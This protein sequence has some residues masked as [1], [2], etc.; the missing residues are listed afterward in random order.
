MRADRLIALLLLLQSRGR[1]T[2]A[3][4]AT[5][6][7]VSVATARRDLEALSAAG[8]PVY[9]QPGRG[10]GWQLIGGARTNLTGLSSHESQALFWL[11]GT[12][13]L[14]S[15]ETQVATMKLIRALPEPMKDEAERL[16]TSIH[17]DHAAWG[18]PARHS[19]AGLGVL[20]DA[21]VRREAIRATYAPRQGERT[22]RT[23]HPLGLVAKAGVWYVVADGGRGPRTYRVDRLSDVGATGEAFDPPQGFDLVAYW[24]AHTDDVEAL[25]SGIAATIEVPAWSVPILQEQFGRY[26]T[27]LQRREEDAVLEVRAHR[28]DGLAE[29]LAGWGS[30]IHVLAPAELRAELARIG[31]DLLSR[32]G[33]E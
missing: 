17:Y 13:G 5:E 6:L 23:L 14:A 2:A 11:L 9:V 15:P 1:V 27:V 33:D 24:Q 4:V 7:E 21:V 31:R 29:Q 18:E 22:A 8:V 10:G 26:V 19:G 16:A 3:T 32:Y 28:L 30:T 12:A 20:R 25:R